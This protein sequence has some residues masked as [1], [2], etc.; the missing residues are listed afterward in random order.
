[1]NTVTCV[2]KLLLNHFFHL[3]FFW[4]IQ[5]WW[6]PT[7]QHTY[8][9]TP[10]KLQLWPVWKSIEINCNTQTLS[11]LLGK[12]NQPDEHILANPFFI[13]LYLSHSR[14]LGVGKKEREREMARRRHSVDGIA[15][16]EETELEWDKKLV[17][18]QLEKSLLT[19]IITCLFPTQI[20]AA[21]RLM[22][23]L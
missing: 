1:M 13:C 5:T 17:A 3:W 15:E 14:T 18:L 23:I 6:V 11:F 22:E 21:K 2:A 16:E 4:K 19:H 7:D 8:V 9:H 10:F 12:C 20:G